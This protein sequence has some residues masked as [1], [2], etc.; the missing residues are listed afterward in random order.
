M[1]AAKSRLSDGVNLFLTI[2]ARRL[3]P[4]LPPLLTPELTPGP[5]MSSPSVNSSV[6]CQDL[7]FS[8]SESAI[9]T[10]SGTKMLFSSIKTGFEKT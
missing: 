5:P 9:G 10:P 7:I 2:A 1:T 4:G 6:I 3:M 8:S